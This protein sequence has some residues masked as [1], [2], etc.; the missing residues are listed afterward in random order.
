MSDLQTTPL[1]VSPLV[2]GEQQGFRTEA[3]ARAYWQLM[4]TKYEYALKYITDPY[5][6]EVIAAVFEPCD[7]QQY[8]DYFVFGE[9]K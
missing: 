8:K 5:T 3:E 7:P 1:T 6:N 2:V 4:P 9:I